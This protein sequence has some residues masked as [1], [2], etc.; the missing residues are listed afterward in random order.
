MIGQVF[1]QA[2]RRDPDQH[3]PW[4]ALVDG[5]NHQLARV[6]AQAQARGVDLAI[7][8]DFGHVLEYLWRAACAS[9]PRS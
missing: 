4:V 1:D 7:V 3:R 5:N 9:S 8:V 2:T 6:H